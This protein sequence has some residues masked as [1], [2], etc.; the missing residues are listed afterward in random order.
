MPIHHQTHENMSTSLER[1]TIIQV[2]A[3]HQA[4]EVLASRKLALAK[5]APTK[6]PHFNL[7]ALVGYHRRQPLMVLDVSRTYHKPPS[8]LV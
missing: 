5:L 7:K 4:I 1:R 3:E 2:V 6:F 8:V